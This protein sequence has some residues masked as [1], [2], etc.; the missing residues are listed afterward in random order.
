MNRRA[1]TLIELLV[2]IA[3]IAIL[4][5]ILFPVFSQAKAAAKKTADLSNQKQL[6]TCVLLYA[7]DN[8]DHSVVT[9]HDLAPTE[10]LADLY[11]WYQPLQP[12]LKSRDVLIDPALG[13]GSTPT[14]FPD[15]LNAATWAPFRTDYVINGFFAHGSSLT[16]FSNPAAQIFTSER[17]R[18]VAF[19]DYHPWASTPTNDWERGMLDGSGFVLTDPETGAIAADA[20]NIGRHTGGSNYAFLD[21][22]AKWF[23][24]V[25]TLDKTKPVNDITNWGMHN[26]DSLPPVEEH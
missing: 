10:T 6:M 22:H 25:N 9:H 21:G 8:D 11:P 24:F 26:I 5:A 4:A 23:K 20:T 17:H 16:G 7:T 18:N 1:F 14:V 12:Y 19:F 2:V 13:A 3:I 15:H